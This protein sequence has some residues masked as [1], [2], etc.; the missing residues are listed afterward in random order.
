M[1]ARATF[2]AP[3]RF[4]VTTCPGCGT[5]FAVEQRLFDVTVATQGTLTCPSGH[6][7]PIGI[8][9]PTEQLIAS[10]RRALGEATETLRQ[11]REEIGR[12]Q[13]TIVDRIVGPET[14]QGEA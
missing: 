13:A 8:E 1:S 12:L 14:A 9:S 6:R 7:A 11:Q 5:P 10:H 4:T 2:D 3:V